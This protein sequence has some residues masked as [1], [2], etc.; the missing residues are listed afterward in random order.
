MNTPI[1][2]LAEMIACLA[3]LFLS[4]AFSPT[5]HAASGSWLNTGA[6]N[7][8]WSTASN[9]VSGTV[10]GATTGTTNADTA[11]FNTA[12][13]TYGTSGTPIVID[14]GRNLQRITFD[15]AAA[16]AY[17]I[18]ATGGNAL[19]LTSAGA[20]TMNAAVANTETINAPLVME[21][22]AG[23]YALTN[24]ATDNSKL[25]NIGGGITGGAAG[26]TVLTLSGTNTG[27]NTISGIIANGAATTL[28][29]TKTGTG[30]WTL[31]GANT[32]TGATTVTQ[33]KLNINNAG[34]LGS[35]TLS[36][37]DA[38]I[39]N[40]SGSA[41]TLTGNNPLTVA[42]NINFGGTN[43]LN[44]GT[45]AVTN[46]AA[47]TFTLNGTGRTLTFGGIWGNSADGALTISVNGVGNTLALGGFALENA[48]STSRQQ[49]LTGTAN[50]SI[51]AI[52][53][54]SSGVAQSLQ[55]AIGG[56]TTLWGA[57]TLTGTLQIWNCPVNINTTALGSGTV[58]FAGAAV[59]ID[60]TSGGA[61]TNTGNTTIAI[62][63]NLTFSGSNDLNLG[64]GAVTGL[65]NGTKTITLNGTGRTLTLGT[66]NDSTW[67]TVL[68]C[69]RKKE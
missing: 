23:T 24:N 31:S 34:A 27:S 47:R 41:I 38:T 60:N 56:T 9:W 59:T 20:I 37:A 48:G 18:G 16:G 43:D 65:L 4:I 42:G 54:G 51:G 46:G 49:A 15:L 22:A 50:L 64:N 7:A 6:A 66:S 19:L 57:N 61:I 26:A 58:N 1:Q 55:I 30:T 63:T 14:S 5:V 52:T 12:V 53:N 25:L 21:G 32:Y 39:D 45:G 11:T 17:T 28:A 36:V 68:R 3:V 29:V 13:G 40:T 2:R 10:P 67:D 33:G 69:G 8:N 62:S 44:L 35:G